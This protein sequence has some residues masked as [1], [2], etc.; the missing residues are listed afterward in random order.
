VKFWRKPLDADTVK[1]PRG[2]IYII[3]E[4]C[5]GC[6]FCVEYCPKKVLELSEEFNKKGYHP[7]VASKEEDCV[8]CGLCELICPEFAIYAEVVEEEAS[9]ETAETAK[10]AAK[11]NKGTPEAATKLEG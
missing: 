2:K 7:P 5:K 8:G 11:T 4:L 3:K 1:P 6:S 9:K 10:K